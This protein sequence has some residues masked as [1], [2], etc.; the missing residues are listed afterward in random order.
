METKKYSDYKNELLKD[1]ELKAEYEN[2]EE[3]FALATEIIELRKEKNITQKQ[4]A[5]E[6]GT[7]QPAIARLES[8]TYTKVSLAFLK[9]VA[10][11]LDAVP[12]IHLRKKAN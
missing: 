12:E 5:D 6:I 7:S 11:A 9:R 2:L 3:D 10:E 1:S 4:L 8:G